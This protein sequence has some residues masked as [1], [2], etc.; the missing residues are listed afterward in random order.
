MRASRPSNTSSSTSR[1]GFSDAALRPA[2]PSVPSVARLR[3]FVT[4]DAPGHRDGRRERP[5]TV[6]C[7]PCK[8]AAPSIVTSSSPWA[9]PHLLHHDGDRARVDLCLL[10]E[11]DGT[12]G[13]IGVDGVEEIL[14][15]SYRRQFSSTMVPSK[16][17][18]SITPTPFG[19]ARWRT[20]EA[21]GRTPPWAG[22]P[23]TN[24]PPLF[25]SR[26]AS[27]LRTSPGTARTRR[28]RRT[29]S[30]AR[31]LHAATGRAARTSRSCSGRRRSAE[32]L[33]RE[34]RR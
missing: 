27:S 6:A 7:T 25:A 9:F 16:S 28:G 24:A 30:A 13:V 4:G 8:R 15:P 33:C 31:S 18:A 10:H 1:G 23:R 22:T 5:E 21:A 2:V 32:D 29:L 3:G 11:G 14:D 20:L 19:F 12:V 26:G 34:G 17:L